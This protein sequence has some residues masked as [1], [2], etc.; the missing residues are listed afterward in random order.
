MTGTTYVGADGSKI[1][2]KGERTVNAITEDGVDTS[3]KFQV[4]PVTK[5]L[6]SVSKMVKTG[7]KVVFDDPDSGEGSYI[8]NKVTGRKTYL[9]HENGIFMLDVWVKPNATGFTRQD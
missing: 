6:G 3:M 5:P 9:R 2:N 1:P 8:Q 7:H 4:C